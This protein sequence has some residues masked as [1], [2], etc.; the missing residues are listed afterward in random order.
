MEDTLT[1]HVPHSVLTMLNRTP[2]ELGRDL[3]LYAALMLFQLGKLSAG[4]AAEMAGMP[5]VM[6]LDL[7]GEYGIP[8]SQMTAD[9]LRH[10]V[11]HE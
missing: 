6:L 7:C 2:A 5:K 10:E 9:E 4:A 1:I 3:R 8:V 11:E